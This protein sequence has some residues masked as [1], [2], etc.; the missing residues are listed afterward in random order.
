MVRMFALALGF[1]TDDFKERTAVPAGLAK[2]AKSYVASVADNAASGW[3]ADIWTIRAT[4]CFW[5]GCRLAAFRH[6]YTESAVVSRC[7][8]TSASGPADQLVETASW[9]K[10]RSTAL[11]ASPSTKFRVLPSANAPMRIAVWG[12]RGCWHK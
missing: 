10:S 8:C 5:A 7:R 9:S 11:N 2:Q 4:D 12:R 3:L 6:E 1:R